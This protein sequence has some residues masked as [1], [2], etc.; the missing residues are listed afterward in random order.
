MKTL[1][2]DLSRRKSILKTISRT[3]PQWKW[4]IVLAITLYALAV[5]IMGFTIILPMNHPT[6][7]EGVFII[8]CA[9]VCHACVPFF[10]ACSVKNKAKY[11]C[12]LP[13]TSYANGTLFLN[14]DSLEYVFWRVGP[15]EP[16]AYS[17]KRAGYRDEHKFVYR[18]AKADIASIDFN[19]DICKI[20]GNGFVQMPEW[21][22]EDATV[23]V[24][25]PEF[26]F[27]LAFEQKNAKEIIT[28]WMG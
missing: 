21:A 28:T 16:A 18:I 26:S 8:I 4:R 6:N 14:D 23:K 27:L 11:K 24:N 22:E 13:Y 15:Q 25:N 5:A 10:I 9:G 1:T 20:K 3:H 7:A 2:P 19:G 12:G 17:S